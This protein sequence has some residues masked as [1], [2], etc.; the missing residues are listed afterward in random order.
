MLSI[1]VV[2]DMVDKCKANYRSASFLDPEELKAKAELWQEMFSTVKEDLFITA[3]NLAILEC[4]DFPNVANIQKSI[5]D[6]TKKDNDIPGIDDSEQKKQE[7]SAEELE[8]AKR[9]AAQANQVVAQGRHKE[10]LIESDNF[11]QAAAYAR[12]KWPEL[13]NER[14]YNGLCSIMEAMVTESKCN[15]C[16]G[17]EC[18]FSYCKT[19]LQLDSRTG[20]ITTAMAKCPKHP[21]YKPRAVSA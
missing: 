14:I 13:S 10:R 17:G 5:K 8:R 21:R 4:S 19:V 2:A 11:A 9:I 7:W 18:P 20:A 16:R 6:L 3:V 1:D 12:R 15:G